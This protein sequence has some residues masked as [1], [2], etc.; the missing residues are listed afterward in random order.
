MIP[1]K[2]ENFFFSLKVDRDSRKNYEVDYR[3]IQ[4]GHPLVY[5]M[6]PTRT[7]GDAISVRRTPLRRRTE[8][9]FISARAYNISVLAASAAAFEIHNDFITACLYSARTRHVVQVVSNP[10]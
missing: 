7:R 1:I 5:I 8:F 2:I 3:G 9:D 10:I 6:P 4:V